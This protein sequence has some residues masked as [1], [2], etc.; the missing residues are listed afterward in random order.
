VRWRVK[1]DPAHDC[2]QGHDKRHESALVEVIG[3]FG[4]VLP[5][6][7]RLPLFIALI[8]KTIIAGVGVALPRFRRREE[9][10]A[11]S[12]PAP[13][14]GQRTAPRDPLPA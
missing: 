12:A 10:G 11:R 4:F 3:Y 13:A 5:K 8:K 1:N 9:R 6:L 7:L 14:A 2:L